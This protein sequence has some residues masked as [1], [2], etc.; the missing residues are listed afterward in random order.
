M[1]NHMSII[2]H[3]SNRIL[4]LEAQIISDAQAIRV[5]LQAGETI[6][7]EDAEEIDDMRWDDLRRDLDIVEEPGDGYRLADDE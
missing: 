7:Y 5:R 3:T 1:E 6:S 2:D 4:P